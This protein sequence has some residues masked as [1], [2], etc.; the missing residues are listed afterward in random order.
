MYLHIFASWSSLAQ[1]R[2]VLLQE[3]GPSRHRARH[4]LEGAG[5]L[6]RADGGVSRGRSTLW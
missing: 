5:G 6:S 3:E 2:L 1:A 4:A